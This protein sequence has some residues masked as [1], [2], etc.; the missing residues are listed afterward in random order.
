MLL[1]K[2]EDSQPG[3]VELTKSAVTL[4]KEL[5]QK[6]EALNKALKKDSELQVTALGSLGV[7]SKQA[8]RMNDNI[9]ERPFDL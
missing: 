2:N 1:K 4:K 8:S 5:A 6:T 7:K 9:A 3:K